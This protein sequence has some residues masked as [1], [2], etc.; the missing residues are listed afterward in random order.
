MFSRSQGQIDE[1]NDL[2][3]TLGPIGSS[4][5]R[6]TTTKQSSTQ[7]R[8]ETTTT[9]KTVALASTAAT[10]DPTLPKQSE[11]LTVLDDPWVPPSDQYSSND[12]I[13]G[14]AYI[15]HIDGN[16][17][18][19]SFYDRP[20]NSLLYSVSAIFQDF[21]YI[22]GGEFYEPRAVK[23]A[24]LLSANINFQIQRLECCEIVNTTSSLIRGVGLYAEILST[25]DGGHEITS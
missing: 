23:F 9:A 22:F 17:Q 20:E 13:A 24:N 6:T 21:V 16:F 3:T 8:N 10:C 2:S 4:S 14:I 1:N 19:E 12:V 7:E 18:R 25:P 15:T 11:H 5:T